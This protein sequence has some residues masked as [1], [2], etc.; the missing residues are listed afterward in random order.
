MDATS[1]TSSGSGSFV[2]ACAPSDEDILLNQASQEHHED[3]ATPEASNK[4]DAIQGACE[5]GQENCFDA[6]A[7]RS[8]DDGT[9]SEAGE[10]T[11]PDSADQQA[12]T[13]C[14]PEETPEQQQVRSRSAK[15]WH[16]MSQRASHK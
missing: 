13:P 15:Q 4:A 1:D 11:R 9:S 6:V 2:S 12:C 7:D 8:L 16:L 10:N 14:E 3:F 5:S